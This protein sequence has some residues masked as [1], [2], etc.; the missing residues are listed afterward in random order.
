MFFLVLEFH[1]FKR[2]HY[3]LG[4]IN[5][6]C[7]GYLYVLTTR[8]PLTI[9]MKQRTI[10]CLFPL[11]WDIVRNAANSIY[12]IYW[13]L[14]KTWLQ[15]TPQYNYIFVM[16]LTCSVHGR[17]RFY[18]TCNVFIHTYVSNH[19]MAWCGDGGA[20]NQGWQMMLSAVI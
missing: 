20:K 18:E 1:A 13:N 17:V 4:T 5:K 15:I 9:T 10:R 12:V 14:S 16:T 7:F 6:D 19:M 3:F 11:Y 8:N 2:I